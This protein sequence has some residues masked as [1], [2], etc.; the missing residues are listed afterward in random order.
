MLKQKDAL[1]LRRC[2]TKFNGFF[3][4]WLQVNRLTLNMELE[5]K[6]A[7]MGAFA[8]CNN[9]DDA[10]LEE[11][12]DLLF[13]ANKLNLI[14]CHK[15]TD[16]GLSFLGNVSVLSLGAPHVA[17]EMN[18]TDEGLKH[19]S[20]CGC[21]S[22]LRCQNITDVGLSYLTSCTE[23]YLEMCTRISNEGLKHLKNCW[24]I[25]L[26][27]NFKIHEGLQYLE[28]CLVISLRGCQQITDDD[29]KHLSKVEEIDLT[30]CGRVTDEGLKHLKSCILLDVPYCRGITMKG[31]FD[32]LSGCR[33]ST[34]E[35]TFYVPKKEEK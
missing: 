6:D 34:E 7:V 11:I 15:V 22:L 27:N 9:I 28:S 17:Y 35:R 8:I 19:L 4:S 30:N 33:V 18:I 24:C 3:N 13:Y 20:K 2:C 32:N 10:A 21:V 12:K 23:I 16:K 5:I 26:S 31:L 14:G 29:L 25:D 1:N